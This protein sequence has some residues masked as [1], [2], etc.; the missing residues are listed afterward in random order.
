[1]V[2]GLVQKYLQGEYGIR[3]YLMDSYWSPDYRTQQRHKQFITLDER[4]RFARL[5]QEAQWCIFDPVVSTL[6]GKRFL[7][8]GSTEDLKHQLVYFNR[9]LRQITDGRSKTPWRCPEAY[10]LQHGKY[11]PNDQTPLAWTQANLL[12]AFKHLYLSFGKR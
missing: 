12:V 8:T 2:L 7:K 4:D 5:G 1:M 10:F 3:R 9:S 6:Y 11:V